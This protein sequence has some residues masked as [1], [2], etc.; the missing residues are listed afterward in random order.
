MSSIHALLSAKIVYDGLPGSVIDIEVTKS[1]LYMASYVIGLQDTKAS[2]T[3]DG[4]F[5][6]PETSTPNPSLAFSC[7][8]Y[9][10]CGGL[11]IRTED[12]E[13][14][15]AVCYHD[16]IFV[17]Q[18]LLLDPADTNTNGSP[19]KRLAGNVG[20]PGLAILIPPNAPE[21]RQPDHQSL[22][23]VNYFPF[24]GRYEDSFEKTSLHLRFTGSTLPV[25]ACRPQVGEIY[26]RAFFYE[27]L[28]QVYDQGVWVAD[29]DV[30]EGVKKYRYG[31][32]KLCLED[33]KIVRSLATIDNWD[34]LLEEQPSSTIVRASGNHL[35]RVAIASVLARLGRDFRILDRYEY[36]DYKPK[37]LNIPVSD[38]IANSQCESHDS[39]DAVFDETQSSDGI[40]AI[41]P[42]EDYYMDDAWTGNRTLTKIAG[43]Y[44]PT[45]W[46]YSDTAPYIGTDVRSQSDSE[47]EPGSWLQK[48]GYSC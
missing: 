13:N 16:S 24:N 32:G 15:I 25:N 45:T 38:W 4:Q 17:A 12:L 9:F 40:E 48:I 5:I 29:L 6:W 42:D 1:P 34:E 3:Q 28:I 41:E 22:R 26:Q 35:A 10:Q 19:V 44:E 46:R 33:G 14:A 11:N 30:L 47:S 7:V 20:Q 27:T 21:I 39:E 36:A 23:V 18:R 31:W 8:C 37:E 43:E 2:A